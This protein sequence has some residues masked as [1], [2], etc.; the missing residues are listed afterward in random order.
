M[1]GRDIASYIIACIF[2]TA[3]FKYGICDKRR[4]LYVIGHMTNSIQE[5]VPFLEEGANVLESDIQ[6]YYNGSV[7]E[8]FHG[9]PGDCFRECDNRVK[10]KEYL[11]YL[12][13]IT[14]PSRDKSYSERLIMQFFD[15]K[16][17]SS[18]DKELSGREIARHIID[19]LWS[20]GEREHEVRVLIYINDVKD[21]DAISGFLQEF[22][23]RG[24]KSRL[25]DVGFDGGLGNIADIRK[26]FKELQINNVWLGD[27]VMNCLSGFYVDGRLR[28]EISVRESNGYIKKVYDW[29]VDAKFKMRKSLDL[30]VD[31]FITNVPA[32][33]V[34]VLKEA[35]YKDKFRIATIN[36]PLFV[37]F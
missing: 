36:D 29:T 26:M 30:E 19:Y 21:K 3:V 28:K 12:R 1:L 7:K 6:F 34:E 5:V 31:G 13:N 37:R 4:P 32:R 20:K 33:L 10:L 35:V 9:C 16:L 27:G 25:K 23:D 8:V 17:D 22:D 11:Q 18:D 15:L 2:F 24:L 14:D